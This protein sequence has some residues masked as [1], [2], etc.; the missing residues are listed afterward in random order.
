MIANIVCR[1]GVGPQSEIKFFVTHG[2]GSGSVPPTPNRRLP[3]G[4]RAVGYY[5]CFPVAHDESGIIR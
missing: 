3:G 4:S 1:S 2:L 5:P